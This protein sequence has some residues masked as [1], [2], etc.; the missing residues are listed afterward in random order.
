LVQSPIPISTDKEKTDHT[1]EQVQSILNEIDD[2]YYTRYFR[3]AETQY[4]RIVIFDLI[5]PSTINPHDYS[6]I[7]H[8]VEDKLT[9]VYPEYDIVIDDVLSEERK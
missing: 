4:K 6:T 7:K 3:L 5:V 8:H 1:N 9:E 2:S